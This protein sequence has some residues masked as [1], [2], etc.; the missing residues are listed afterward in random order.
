MN[1]KVYLTIGIVSIILGL[2]GLFFY[3]IGWFFFSFAD[4]RLYGI[5]IGIILS[6]FA[7]ILGHIAKKQDD[8]Y[9]KYGI[10]L[11]GIVVIIAL[12]TIAITTP[13]S[14]EIGYS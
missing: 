6:I 4:N 13:T 10:I 5:V 11:G 1:N 9:G 2:L 7:I 8:C 14:V 12:T 3:F